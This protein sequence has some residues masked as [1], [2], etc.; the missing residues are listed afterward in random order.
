M[1][2][3]DNVMG[4]IWVPEDGFGTS[5]NMGRTNLF[6]KYETKLINLIVCMLDSKY[7][8]SSYGRQDETNK[9]R[10][11]RPCFPLPWFLGRF[12]CLKINKISISRQH[13]GLYERNRN[14]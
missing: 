6:G 14:K 10:C 7:N 2:V 5:K 4:H 8:E 13:K 3:T 1:M 9:N 11:Y 12:Q